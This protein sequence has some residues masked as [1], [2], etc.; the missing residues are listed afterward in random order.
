MI[1]WCGVVSSGVWFGLPH[2][3]YATRCEEAMFI[4]AC[5]FQFVPATRMGCVFSLSSCVFK[6]NQGY[7]ETD[8]VLVHFVFCRPQ[9]L[10]CL[11]IRDC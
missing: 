10:L 9:M 7:H 6:E 11:S 2:L 8:I 4:D 1:G 5:T 3:T